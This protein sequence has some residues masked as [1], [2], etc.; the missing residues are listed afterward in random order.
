VP[1]DNFSDAIGSITSKKMPPGMGYPEAQSI[2]P[3]VVE[4]S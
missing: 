2:R 1:V 3:S 4:V